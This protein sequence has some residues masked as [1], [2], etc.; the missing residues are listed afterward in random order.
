MAEQR[1]HLEGWTQ[2]RREKLEAGPRYESGVL[3]TSLEARR[4]TTT[5]ALKRCRSW[6]G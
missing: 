4:Q 2:A 5:R 6:C 1:L 3:V